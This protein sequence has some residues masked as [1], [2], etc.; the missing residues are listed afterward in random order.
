MSKTDTD[1][2][3][4]K[5]CG[6][7]WKEKDFE[8]GAAVVRKGQV[9]CRDCYDKFFPGE[10]PNHPGV[11]AVTHCRVCGVKW[12]G[13]C[14]IEIQGKQ[15]CD[16]CKEIALERIK[17]GLPVRKEKDD[18]GIPLMTTAHD[19][20]EKSVEEQK[21]SILGWTV[22]F[23]FAVGIPVLTAGIIMGEKQAILYGAVF[24]VPLVFGLIPLFVR[25]PEKEGITTIVITDLRISQFV[26]G[27]ERITID[28]SDVLR[29]VLKRRRGAV[30]Y[31][32]CTIEAPGRRITV[33]R[34]Y[35]DF[36][37]V[38]KLVLSICEERGIKC[39]GA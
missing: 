23:A 4:C 18:E 39:R 29:V 16:G 14:V 2:Y 10:C 33:D 27:E 21:R 32:K 34:K 1:R 24:L 20:A 35:R 38:V 26:S 8:R 12:C 9:L 15:V 7:G 17:R 28:W 30:L 25:K 6:A 11:E 3:C 13:D 5:S 22:I 36:G 37:D 19:K 31:S